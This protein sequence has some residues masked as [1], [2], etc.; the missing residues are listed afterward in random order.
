MAKLNE[1]SPRE[2]MNTNEYH[3]KHNEL[4]SLI[5]RTCY[6]PNG[7]R[8]E[9]TNAEKM[10]LKLAKHIHNSEMLAMGI[11]PKSQMNIRIDDVLRSKLQNKFK[12]K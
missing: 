4:Q 7:K 8:F 10:E 3:I 2:Y 12:I 11:N 6:K 5:N 1:I 9:K